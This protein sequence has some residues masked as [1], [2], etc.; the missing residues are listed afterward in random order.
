MHDPGRRPFCPDLRWS[1]FRWECGPF[2]GRQ[3]GE[4]LVTRATSGNEGLRG[5]LLW[6][7]SDQGQVP[8]SLHVTMNPTHFQNSSALVGGEGESP[9]VS[10]RTQN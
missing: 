6:N 2:S 3:W 5:L 10:V 8:L 9:Q 4:A 1:L 7:E